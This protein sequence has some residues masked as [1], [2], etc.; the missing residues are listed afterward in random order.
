MQDSQPFWL[1]LFVGLAAEE[2]DAGI[3]F[4][5]VATGYAL[6]SLR[7]Q[8]D[9]FASLIPPSGDDHIRVQRAGGASGVHLDVHARNVKAAATRAADLG[10]TLVSFSG[11]A[12]LRS[13]AGFGFCLVGDDASRPA[14]PTVWPGGHRALVDQ[15]T[16]DI[17]PAAYDDEVHFWS[18]LTGW[19]AR[20]A[21]EFVRLMTPAALPVRVL[22]QRTGD[23]PAD[24]HLDIATDNRPAEVARL[25]ALGAAV[26]GGGAQWTV[27]RPP[28]GP[29]CCVT[30][31][32]PDTG[33]LPD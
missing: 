3:A 15:L 32:D 27:L 20:P 26:I 2:W 24:G 6:S 19:P 28:A 30:D 14:S 12:V 21:G 22:L 8:H 23:R 7:G 4:W 33:L 10:A 5:A 17:P 11:Y 18:E 25:G 1:T 16:I 13:P 31:R 29:L 9:E